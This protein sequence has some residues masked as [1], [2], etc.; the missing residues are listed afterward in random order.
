MN[1]PVLYALGC[2]LLAAGFAAAPVATTA[3]MPSATPTPVPITKPDFSPMNFYMG[4]WTCT[5]PL[6]GGTRSE[7]DVYT[8]SN[9]GMWMID[10]ATSP[11]FDA[12]R[13]VPQNSMTYMTYDPT[14]KQW[15][16]VF[17]DNFGGYGMGSS[18]GWQGN[19]ATWSATGLDGTKV[20][21]VVTKISE[22]Q[23]TDANTITDPQGK[24]TTVT[25]T[26]KK[27]M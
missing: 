13:T 17:M 5:Q 12:Y 2:A 4:T 20:G 19:A 26:C 1:R 7:T 11:P 6:R 10:T 15:V 16:Q 8:M 3:Q 23:T 25:I 14:V 9:D 21:D 24:V 22:T 27:S 18:S